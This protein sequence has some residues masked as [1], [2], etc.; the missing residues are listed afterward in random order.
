MKGDGRCDYCGKEMME[1]FTTYTVTV[2]IQNVDD[3]VK[4][5]MCSAGCQ[6]RF[7]EELSIK[8]YW[9]DTE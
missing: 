1:R 2:L 6:E 7:E 5:N 3:S 8:H 4:A 9:R